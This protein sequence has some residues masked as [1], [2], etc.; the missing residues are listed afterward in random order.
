MKYKNKKDVLMLSTFHGSD[1]K[2]T[3][4]RCRD[5][6]V[7][8]PTVIID[9]NQVKGGSDLSDQ[10]ISYYNPAHKSI[11]WFQKVLFQCISIAQ[12]NSFV[13]YNKCYAGHGMRTMKLEAFYKSFSKFLTSTKVGT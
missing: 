13:L 10:L 12:L 1:F 11:K 6:A 3:G 8:K 4:K 5:E 2:D 7:I 9:Y